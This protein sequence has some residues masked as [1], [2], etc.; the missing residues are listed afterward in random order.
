[1]V[2]APYE[3]ETIDLWALNFMFAVENVNP[4]FGRLEVSQVHYELNESFTKKLK[5]IT[6]VDCE[7][8]HAKQGFNS[9][10]FKIEK[11]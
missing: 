7:E 4:R 3:D 9:E 2:V 11:L 6:M 5:P 1:M 10:H 8:L